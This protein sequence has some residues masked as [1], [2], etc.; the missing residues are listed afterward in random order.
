L[1]VSERRVL[2]II[3]LPKTTTV[4]MILIL[5]FHSDLMEELRQ[6]QQD[7]IQQADRKVL[8]LEPGVTSDGRDGVLVV[9][10]DS[11]DGTSSDATTTPRPAIIPTTEEL[12]AYIQDLPAYRRICKLQQDAMQ[13]SDE[14]VAIAEQTQ[15]LVDATVRRLDEDLSKLES[16]VRL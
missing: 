14:K 16:Y 5:D 2:M 3:I 13:Q 10:N 1:F 12:Q 15:A 8:Q 4:L 11:N 7:Y 6:A 9:A